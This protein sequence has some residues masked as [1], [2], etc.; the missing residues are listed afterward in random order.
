MTA[1]SNFEILPCMSSP[2]YSGRGI[3][4]LAE[5]LEK[6]NGCCNLEKVLSNTEN[7]SLL[8]IH[9]KV[10]WRMFPPVIF[11]QFISWC[12]PKSFLINSR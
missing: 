8:K 11:N 9:V 12:I 5:Y 10:M 6:V 4:S 2:K 7:L 3:A 1:V